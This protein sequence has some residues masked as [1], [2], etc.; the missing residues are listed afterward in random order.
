MEGREVWQAL[1]ARLTAARIALDSGDRERA[2]AE[3]S[4]ALDIDPYFLA[5]QSL[6]EHILAPEAPSTGLADG[7]PRP[8]RKG[9]NTTAPTTSSGVRP[10]GSAQRPPVSDDRYSVFE[11]RVRRRRVS[12]QL[13][14]ARAALNAGHSKRAATALE[15]LTELDPNLAELVAL[16]QQLGHVHLTRA[17]AR[18]G[19]RFAAVGVFLSSVL[20]ASVLQNPTALV[21]RPMV[22]RSPFV[23]PSPAVTVSSKA[24]L[25]LA[26]DREPARSVS[27][28]LAR[29]VSSNVEPSA[30]RAAPT[31][32]RAASS[33]NATITM[34][35]PEPAAAPTRPEPF[36][37]AT[38]VE[39]IN[40][41][42]A[43]SAGDNFLVKQ[44]LQ[45]YRT[46]YEEL[47][48]RS[49]QTVWPAVNQAALARAFDGLASQALTFDMCDVRVR[50]ESATAMCQGSARYV[51]KI[52]SRE[53]RVEPR[54]WT[55]TLQKNRGDWKIDSARAER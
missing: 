42:A 33:V 27:N 24:A 4:A 40:T 1:H 39:V 31:S 21:S 12:R 52:G 38:V 43:D 15:E 18:P 8:E 48:A 5:A 23:A 55:F 54:V 25:A 19:P 9:G 6:R 29:S 45:L 7:A 49:A 50:G 35:P 46:A 16:R 26:D 34:P 28:R 14:A 53:P 22:A 41:P 51:P 2:L 32:A 36:H 30:V 20:A 17:A 37:E 47:D 10:K 13:D 44:T 3:T 11:Q